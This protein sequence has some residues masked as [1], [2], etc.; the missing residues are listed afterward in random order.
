MADN[1]ASSVFNPQ[2]FDLEPTTMT[3]VTAFGLLRDRGQVRLTYQPG[4]AT[5]YRLL[6]VG[7]GKDL[8]VLW[9]NSYGPAEVK[10]S[11]VLANYDATDGTLSRTEPYMLHKLGANDHVYCMIAGFLNTIFGHKP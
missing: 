9:L 5:R 7:S 6:L 4:D 1:D 8:F 10:A 11:C 3:A 2:S